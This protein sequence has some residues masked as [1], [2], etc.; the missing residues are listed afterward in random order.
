MAKWV[1]KIRANNGFARPHGGKAHNDRIDNMIKKVNQ[2]SGV[3]DV[4]K[5]QVQVDYDGNRVGNNRPDIQFNKDGVHTNIEYDTQKRS[6]EHHRKV[7]TDNDP[8]ARNKFYKI[9]DAN[10]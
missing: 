3:T 1:H 4:R 10:K 5:N 2:N 9:N 6:M 8:N 7:V